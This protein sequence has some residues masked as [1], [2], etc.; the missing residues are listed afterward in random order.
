VTH[1]SLPR[2]LLRIG[3]LP[4]RLRNPLSNAAIRSCVHDRVHGLIA[5]F[6]GSGSGS[7]RLTYG[8]GVLAHRWPAGPGSGAVARGWELRTLL[9]NRACA[10]GSLERRS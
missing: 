2:R 3:K 1:R 5:A 7:G 8:A 6:S 10:P 4:E 9:R